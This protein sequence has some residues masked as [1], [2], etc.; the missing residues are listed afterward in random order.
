M[1]YLEFLTQ[2]ESLKIAHTRHRAEKS[3]KTHSEEKPGSSPKATVSKLIKD[4][5]LHETAPLK[6]LL[7]WQPGNNTALNHIQFAVLLEKSWRHQLNPYTA[8]DDTESST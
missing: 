6:R 7:Q 3:A 1:T 2:L 4:S 8:P 5:G